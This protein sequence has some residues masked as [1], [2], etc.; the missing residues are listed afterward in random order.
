MCVIRTLYMYGTIIDRTTMFEIMKESDDLDPD[1]DDYQEVDWDIS[2]NYYEPLRIIPIPH[3]QIENNKNKKKIKYI[4]GVLLEEKKELAKYKV[5]TTSIKIGVSKK[6]R[7]KI[8]HYLK[9]ILK[10]HDIIITDN[11]ISYITIPHRCHCCYNPYI[12]LG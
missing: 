3:D 7:N 6:E 8:N 5:G 2:M 10:N 1:V 9:L 4:M 11:D 12:H